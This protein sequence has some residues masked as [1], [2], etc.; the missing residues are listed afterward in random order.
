MEMAVKGLGQDKIIFF[1]LAYDGLTPYVKEELDCMCQV[2]F[3][4]WKSDIVLGVVKKRK[5]DIEN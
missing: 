1:E 5:Y 2:L 3:C 4:S